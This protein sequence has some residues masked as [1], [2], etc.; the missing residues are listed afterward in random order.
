VNETEILPALSST[1]RIPAQRVIEAESLDSCGFDVP[2]SGL[3]ACVHS[4][5]VNLCC[6][7][8]GCANQ[9]W[10]CGRPVPFYLQRTD[11]PWQRHAKWIGI[12]LLVWLVASGWIVDLFWSLV[13]IVFM[14]AMGILLG[15]LEVHSLF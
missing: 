12:A 8:A 10:W 5:V 1:S 9:V 11:S 14:G 13:L 6:V 2:A 3:D 4:T 7:C 15:V